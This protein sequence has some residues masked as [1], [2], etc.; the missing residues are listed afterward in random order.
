M[1]PGANLKNNL[2]YFHIFVVMKEKTKNSDERLGFVE[3]R[4]KKGVY[5][6]SRR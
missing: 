6:P 3:I 1:L 5:T 2:G 4:T